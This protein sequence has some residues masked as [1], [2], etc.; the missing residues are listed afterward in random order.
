MHVCLYTDLLGSS[1]APLFSS[2]FLGNDWDLCL[3][4]YNGITF[5]WII[6]ALSGHAKYLKWC[7]DHREY[8]CTLIVITVFSGHAYSIRSSIECIFFLIR[9]NQKFRTRCLYQ[10]CLYQ[11]VFSG[12]EYKLYVILY[13]LFF[14]MYSMYFCIHIDD[15]IYFELNKQWTWLIL[16]SVSAISSA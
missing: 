8:H 5:H 10:M 15:N 4:E 3:N 7:L 9:R 13:Y 6:W 12:T 1:A 11:D 2:V 16:S 14:G